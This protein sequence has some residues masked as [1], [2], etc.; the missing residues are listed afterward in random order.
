M[1]IAPLPYPRLIHSRRFARNGF[2][3]EAAF[4]KQLVDG[5]NHIMAYRRKTFLT[6]NETAP[7]AGSAGTVTRYRAYGHT[8]HGAT[9]VGFIVGIGL[10]T[11]STGAS[12]SVKVS[13][14]T[15]TTGTVTQ[16]VYAGLFNGTPTDSPSEITYHDGRLA[17]T[18]N[19]TVQIVVSTSD[20]ARIFSI[21][22]Y[23]IASDIVD[24]AVN[25]YQEVTPAAQYPIWDSTRQVHNVGMSQIWRHNG[26]HI[27]T[28]PGS[29][30]GTSPTYTG[31]T[32]W[33]NVIDSA[34]SVTAN[35]AGF[36]LGN[37]GLDLSGMQRYG[38]TSLNVVFAAHLSC[39]GSATADVRLEDSSG[40]I[41]SMTGK[42]TASA[43]YTATTTISLSTLDKAD[44]QF[45]TSNAAN[46]V[47]LNAVS[48]YAYLA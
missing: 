30:T 34:T 9:H 25:Y 44:L 42:G 7:A 31:G 17:V 1:A 2:V 43:W 48:L 3:T 27:M 12:P 8:G 35:T 45:R 36:Y 19:E 4:A 32:T 5:Q 47:T 37:V 28:W 26:G 10:D 40:T 22:V 11:T 6:A 39:T 46:T 18:A 29:G 14:T 16:D 23:E 15:A 24:S 13:A 20:Y 41:C 21:L 38:D 33:T